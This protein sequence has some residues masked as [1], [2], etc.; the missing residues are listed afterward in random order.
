M[1]KPEQLESQDLNMLAMY[2][3]RVAESPAANSWQAHQASQ[4]KADW[5]LYIGHTHPP[6][7]GV[8]SQEDIV[9][10]GKLLKEQMLRFLARCSSSLFLANAPATPTAPDTKANYAAPALQKNFEQAIHVKWSVAR[11]VRVQEEG[12]VN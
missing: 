4:L 3:L 1:P 5:A 6:I 10:Y 7:P 8:D 2:C 12:E 9:L 11:P